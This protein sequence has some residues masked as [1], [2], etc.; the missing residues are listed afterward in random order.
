[1]ILEIVSHEIHDVDRGDLQQDLHT[2]TSLNEFL[3]ID[4][5]LNLLWQ[6]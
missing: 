3:S 6:D 4:F 2:K 1:M 5:L